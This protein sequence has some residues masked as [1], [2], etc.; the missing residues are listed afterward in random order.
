MPTEDFSA[1]PARRRHYRYRIE[2]SYVIWIKRF[3][4]FHGKRDSQELAW[5]RSPKYLRAPHANPDAGTARIRNICS[6]TG[7]ARAAERQIV[8]LTR[9]SERSSR[10]SGAAASSASFG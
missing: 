10:V 3:I 7:P 5:R 2:E 8:A 1:P 6:Q 9:A 4:N